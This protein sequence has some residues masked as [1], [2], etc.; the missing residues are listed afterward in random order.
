[1]RA[2]KGNLAMSFGKKRSK[3]G[4]TDGRNRNLPTALRS[5]IR[6]QLDNGAGR[7]IEGTR[8]ASLDGRSRTNRG[9]LL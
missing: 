9:A 4:K 1:M 7:G 3:E 8:K 5:E 6:E 2:V